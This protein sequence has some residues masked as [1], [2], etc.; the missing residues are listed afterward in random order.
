M[1]PHSLAFCH[2]CALCTTSSNSQGMII[3][4]THTHAQAYIRALAHTPGEQVHI[5]LQAATV[6]QGGEMSD[7][8]WVC[9]THSKSAR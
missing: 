7:A 4:I 3:T 1:K 2:F 5:A 6:R 8:A 9:V